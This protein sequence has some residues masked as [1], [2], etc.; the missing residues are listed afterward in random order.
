VTF[1]ATVAAGGAPPGYS[2]TGWVRLRQ[3]LLP[4]RR[5][6]S[7][8]T[9]SSRQ[10]PVVGTHSITASYGGDATFA[11]SGSGPLNQTVLAKRRDD[12][13]V[14]REHRVLTTDVTFTATGHRAGRRRGPA[15]GWVSFYDNGYYLGGAQLSGGTASSRRPA[16]VGAH[17]ITAYTAAT[18]LSVVQLAPLTEDNSGE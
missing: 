2:P 16:W 15:T 17:T 7:A 10:Q 6:V 12:R 5:G 13:S 1:I 11:D 8:G 4:R 3:R 9:A 18:A 14:R